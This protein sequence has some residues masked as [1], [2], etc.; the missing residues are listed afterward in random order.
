MTAAEAPNDATARRGREQAA[1]WL[2]LAFSALATLPF[3]VAPTPQLTDYPSHLARYVVMLDGGRDAFLAR[4][5]DFEWM[6]NG[7]LGADLLMVPLGRMMG[8]ETA[9]WLIGMLLPALTGLGIIAVSRAVYGRVGFGAVL[10]FATI[11]SPAMGMGFY[12]F[13]LALACALLAFALWV[14]MDAVRWRWAV[15]LP[16]GVLVWLCHA[17]GWGVLGVLVFGYE[18]GRRKSWRAFVAPWPLLLALVPQ[19]MAP[20]AKGSL[21]YGANV[22]R[23]KTLVWFQALRDQ[24]MIADVTTLAVIGLAVLFAL[25]CRRV[26][27]R[28]GWAALILGLLT[29]VMPRHLGGGDYADYRL[30]AVTLMIGAL[31]IDA[32][33][34]LALWL[35][36]PALFLWRLELTTLGWIRNGARTQQ[37]LEALDHIPRGAKVASAVLIETRGWALDPLEHVTSFATVRRAV[38][39]NAHFA[40]PGIHMLRLREGGPGFADPSHRVFH[41]PGRPVDLSA[42]PP[43][44]RADWLWYVGTRVPDR[45]PPGAVVTWR[46]QGGLV[47]RLAKSPAPR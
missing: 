23:Y 16:V 37:A 7:N 44:R 36:A 47:A 24:D 32:R 2:A 10:A 34:P 31:A 19:L 21:E 29:I 40:I 41:H 39:T 38:L 25:L 12:N 13:C 3:W 4:Y 30:I 17:S 35:I 6:L 46:G 43:A 22:V 20:A 8:A 1:L 26:D 11:W 14:R 42:F 45:L 28:L 9:A 15:F 33:P 27:G 5:Y 18:W